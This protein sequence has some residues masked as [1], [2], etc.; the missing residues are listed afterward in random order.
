MLCVTAFS[1]RAGVYHPDKTIKPL[2]PVPGTKSGVAR[3][4][5]DRKK[6]VAPVK[7]KSSRTTPVSTSAGGKKEAAAVIKSGKRIITPRVGSQ[8]ISSYKNNSP[9]SFAPKNFQ[10]NLQVLQPQPEPAEESAVPAATPVRRSRRVSG[11]QP[12]LS[13]TPA[14]LTVTPARR[15]KERSASRERRP[16]SFGPD[17][18][19]DSA[20]TGHH[21]LPLP[22]LTEEVVDDK[23]EDLLVVTPGRDK[24]V[25][26]EA[27]KTPA[28]STA[29]R[30]RTRHSSLK[31][32]AETN[33]EQDAITPVSQLISGISRANIETEEKAEAFKTP[34][35]T[36]VMKVKT[37]NLQVVSPLSSI[38]TVRGSSKRKRNSPE[39]VNSVAALFEGLEESPLLKKLEAKLSKN[40]EITEEDFALPPVAKHIRLDL[41]FDKIADEKEEKV[42]SEPQHDV[43]HFR[44]L[45]TSET[46]RLTTLCQLWE[47][48]LKQKVSVASVDEEVEGEVRSVIGQARL[49]MAE[50]F[51][52]FSG[53]V[54]NCEF[55][56]G[57]KETT[58]TDLMG[59]WEMI[60]FQVID[61]D[62][63]FQKLKEIE[64]NDW[65]LVVPKPVQVKKKPTKKAVNVL[66]KPASSSLK[67][68]IAAKR[69]AAGIPS[70]DK[71]LSLR[72]MM[73]QKRAEMVTKKKDEREKE[74]AMLASDNLFDGGF[75]QVVSPVRPSPKFSPKTQSPKAATPRSVA[76]DNLRRSVL[77]ETARRTS[78]SGLLLSPF[79]SQAARRSLSAAEPPTAVLVDVEDTDRVSRTPTRRSSRVRTP[80]NK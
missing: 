39:A 3:T 28:A 11:V 56:R 52:Q 48:K 66:Q 30:R 65:K 10:F 9:K 1:P 70:V 51:S 37:S 50:R 43:A 47:E 35:S 21:P 2:P 75:F 6:L 16:K 63:K 68:M 19:P 76:G 34:K 67:A 14:Q 53:L 59:F 64:E 46:E 74:K 69:K 41:D 4:P 27:M 15:A 36:R 17:F 31:I 13:L 26:P 5:L 45:L 72:E 60:Y 29:R 33:E 49:V 62:K 77:A 12:D 71:P 18:F 22:S 79:I 73:A 61:V 54:D 42:V 78:V 57:E 20:S 25:E 80:L 23:T 40:E 24:E 8:L 7:P 38:S 58:T 44:S 55:K 32:I